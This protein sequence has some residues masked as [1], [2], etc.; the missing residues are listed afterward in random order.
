MGAIVWTIEGYRS[1]MSWT[2]LC[3]DRVARIPGRVEHAPAS[4]VLETVNHRVALIWID[5]I[6][7]VSE[8]YKSI[9]WDP[10]IDLLIDRPLWNLL[11]VS[12]GAAILPAMLCFRFLRNRKRFGENHCIHC[13][14]DLRAS[15]EQCPECGTV[16]SETATA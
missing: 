14:Y 9:G 1:N 12:L 8:K 13:G 15:P 5:P 16:R 10:E 4:Y 6:P 11:L 3:A 7:V 2:F